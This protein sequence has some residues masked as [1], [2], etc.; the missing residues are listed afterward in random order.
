[1]TTWPG[2]LDEH[3]RTTTWLA[4]PVG[5]SSMLYTAGS[6]HHHRGFPLTIERLAFN[7]P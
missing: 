3:D 4:F 5:Q 6:P 2:I 7:E 1:M